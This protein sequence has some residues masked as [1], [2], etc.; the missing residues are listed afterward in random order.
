MKHL[1]A[2]KRKG[3]SRLIHYQTHREHVKNETRGKHKK[4]SQDIQKTRGNT[5]QETLKTQLKK[6]QTKNI[7]TPKHKNETQ[8][9]QEEQQ[10]LNYEM[11]KKT[12]PKD[13]IITTSWF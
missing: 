13:R 12:Q 5:Q 7:D 1:R 11:K 2:I 8:P 3:N 6:H 9:K 4:N 10:N